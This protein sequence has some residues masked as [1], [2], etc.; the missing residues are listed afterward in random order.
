MSLADPE[1]MMCPIL[2]SAN[3]KEV[4]CFW[5]FSLYQPDCSSSQSTV[6]IY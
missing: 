1:Y 3:D 6:C 2:D 4:I 5:R